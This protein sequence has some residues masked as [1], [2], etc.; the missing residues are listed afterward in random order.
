MRTLLLCFFVTAST[1]LSAQEICDN[2]L[3]D[4]GDGL[5][6]IQDPDCFCAP[7][8]P[9]VTADFEE[10]SCCPFSFTNPFS[11]GF[12]C[13]NDGWTFLGQGTT[14]YFN[15]CGYTGGDG[16]LPDIPTPIPSGNGAMGIFSISSS[17][18]YDEP[19]ARCLDCSFIAGET[20]DV[21]FF[22]GFA[23]CCGITSSDVE[24]S[25][26]A[27]ADC[28]NIPGGSLGCAGDAGWTELATFPV[29]AV[30]NGWVEVT[31]S[32]TS[33]GNFSAVALGKSCAFV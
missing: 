3:D 9:G 13:V 11:T 32:F 27:K 6:D 1:I 2:G 29:T 10:F 7:A 12:G 17:Q 15:T 5:F 8:F 23:E 20:Y 24:I 16:I 31:G 4:D 30:N 33:S 28:S 26:F 18:P 14:D 25:I 21:S 19:I 22:V